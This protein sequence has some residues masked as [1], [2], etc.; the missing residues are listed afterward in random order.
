MFQLIE[1][2][3]GFTQLLILRKQLNEQQTCLHFVLKFSENISEIFKGKRKKY[4][5]KY[6]RI[7]SHQ[8]NSCKTL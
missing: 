5:S 3:L 7:Q 8:N 6:F 2:A 4:R 1:K